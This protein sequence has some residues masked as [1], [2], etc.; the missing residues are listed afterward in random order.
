MIKKRRPYLFSFAFHLILLLLFY[1]IKIGLEPVQDEYVTIDFG[2]LGKQS[3]SGVLAKTPTEDIQKK[4]PE[5]QKEIVEKVVKK[6]ELPQ[7]ENPDEMN[8][9]VI[10]ADKKVSED[11][12]KPEII[13]PI[14]KKEEEA[15]KGKDEAGEGEGDFGFEID[16]GGTG[17]RKIYSYS[18]PS[19]SSHY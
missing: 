1:L 8:N 9:V 10:S 11:D 14:V 4:Q 2:A 15:G 6:V 12:T 5:V 16:F 18:L 7:I 13:E 17:M 3:S 19:I